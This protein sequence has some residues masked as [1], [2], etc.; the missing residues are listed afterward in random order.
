M[1]KV[2][3]KSNNNEVSYGKIYVVYDVMAFLEFDNIRFLV[4]SDSE[5][6]VY[7]SSKCFVP[8]GDPRVKQLSYY[9]ED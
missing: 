8:Y 3:C 1:F 9:E 5:E 7:I 2:V 4:F 6:F